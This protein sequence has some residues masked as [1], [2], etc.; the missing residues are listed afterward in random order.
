MRKTFG[1]SESGGNSA[2]MSDGAVAGTTGQ[3]RR[4]E[5]IWMDVDCVD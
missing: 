2:W 3:N 1:N 5:A 4:I